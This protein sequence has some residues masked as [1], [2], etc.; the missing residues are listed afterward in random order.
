MPGY[1][2]IEDG[3]TPYFVY[4]GNDGVSSKYYLVS[5][6]NKGVLVKEDRATLELI[7]E[8]PPVK[9]SEDGFMVLDDSMASSLSGEELKRLKSDIELTNIYIEEGLLKFDQNMNVIYDKRDSTID[10]NDVFSSEETS[11]HSNNNPFDDDKM[12]DSSEAATVIE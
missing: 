5:A 11:Y 3:E 6:Y 2:Y 8:K 9:L 7:E 12:N 10:S 4:K 1:Y